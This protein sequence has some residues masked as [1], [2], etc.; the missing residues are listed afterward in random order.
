MPSCPQTLALWTLALLA[1][2]TSC[3]ATS[4]LAEGY[5]VRVWQTE[6]GLP[7]N[8]VTSAVQTRN[9][10][11]W[12]GTE[13]GLARFDGERFQ[14]FNPVNTPELADRRAARLF[15]DAQGTLWIGHEAGAITQYRAGRFTAFAPSSGTESERIIGLGGDEQGRLW[16]MRENGA[17]DSFENGN[18][19]PSLIAPARPGMMYWSRSTNGQIWLSENGQV[20]RLVDGELQKVA[21]DST[22]GFGYCIAATSDGGAW[23]FC[24]DRIRKWKD[25]RWTE[26]RGGYAW[27]SGTLS[28]SLELSDGT[29]AVGTINSGI[30][31]IFSDGRR[32]VRFDGANGLPQNWVR[33]LHEDRE[34]SLWAGTSAGLVSIHRTAFSVLNAPDQWQGCSVLSVA[35]GRDNTLWIGTD[36]AG[37]YRYSAGEWSHFGEDSGLGNLYITAVTESARG[38]AWAGNHWWGGPYRLEGGSFV[39]PEGV[40]ET[41]SPVL[42]LQAISGTGELLVGN[43]EGLLKLHKARSTWLMKSPEGSSD[44]VCAVVRD[45]DGVIWCGFT[46][47]GLARLAGGEVMIYRRKDGLGSDS[48]QCLFADDDGSLW[49]GTAD[50]GLTRFKDGRFVTLGVAQGIADDIV[51]HILDDDLGYFWLSTHHGIQRVAK[52]ELDRCADGLIPAVSSQI[53]DDSDG[54]P[55]IEFL[56]GRQAAGCKTSDGRLWFASSKGVVSVDPTRIETNTLE[57]PVHFESLLVDGKAVSSTGGIVRDRLAP[58]HERLEFQFSGLSFV[59]P[60]KVLFKYRLDGIDKTWVEAG[61]KRT[62]FYSRLPAGSYRFQVIACNNDGLW[63]TTGASLAFTIAPFFWETWWFVTLCLMV[64]AVVVAL[65]ARYLTRRHMQRKIEKMEREHEIERERARIAQDIHDDVGASLS[66]IAM[67][68]QPGR[69]DLVEPGRTAAMLSR[70]YTTAREVTRSLDEIVWAVDPRHDT[71]DSLVDYMGRFAQEFLTTANLRCRLDLPVEVPAWPLTAEIRHN[72]FLAFKE[73]LNN[74]VRH[75]SASEVRISVMLHSEFFELVVKDNGRGFD[76]GHSEQADPD[77]L[78][79]GNGLANMKKRLARIGGR[80]E[81]SSESGAGTSVTF[82]LS[83]D[84]HDSSEPSSSRASTP[85]AT[86]PL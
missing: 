25:G 67:L 6:D 47:G 79:A 2:S 73:A 27:P 68:S 4:F 9:G 81:I 71:L 76:K 64:A 51:C 80:C 7:Q 59:A 75:A 30:Y 13:S 42:A 61:P 20:A 22:D 26:D 36:G 45:R 66:R 12:F 82:M 3:S 86:Q 16:A 31:L 24:D 72:L 37:L 40:D 41:S 29:L 19:L 70:I 14:V 8:M 55:I 23:I 35:P 69:R 28:C 5:S 11:L 33:F 84:V 62:A 77:R 10:Y 56:G 52:D 57:P 74:V 78:A 44:D 18:R 39:R 34:G 46:Q 1:T 32:P 48:V 49:I 15:E 43:R 58:D 54:L 50:K 38:E 21:L 85:T 60:S 17:V 83:F 53:Y 65:L 63:N